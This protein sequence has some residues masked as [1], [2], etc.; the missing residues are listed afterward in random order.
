MKK[1]RRFD[2]AQEGI[3]A[4]VRQANSGVD[5]RCKSGGRESVSSQFCREPCVGSREGMDEASVAVRVGRAMEPFSFC[6][7]PATLEGAL[8]MASSLRLRSRGTETRAA[9]FRRVCTG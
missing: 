9:C 7:Y 6:P 8:S 1:L 4:G 2:P 3:R 5:S